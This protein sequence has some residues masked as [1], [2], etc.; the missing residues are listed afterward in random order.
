MVRAAAVKAGAPTGP[1]GWRL[2]GPVTACAGAPGLSRVSGVMEEQVKTPAPSTPLPGTPPALT[3][4]DHEDKDAEDED[5][6]D[7][8]EGGWIPL[9]IE[10]EQLFNKL[11]ESC[12]HIFNVQFA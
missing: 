3:A 10:E 1:L 9:D 12:N 4:D 5:V 8:E 6:E 2:L 11:K 7:T